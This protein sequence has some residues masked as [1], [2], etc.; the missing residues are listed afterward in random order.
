MSR[1]L[2]L[3]DPFEGSGEFHRRI[4]L[5]VEGLIALTLAIGACGLTSAMWLRTLAPLVHQL[6]LG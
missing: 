4:R 2:S 3:R 1:L 6:G 5:R